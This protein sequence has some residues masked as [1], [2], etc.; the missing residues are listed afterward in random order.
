[1]TSPRVHPAHAGPPLAALAVVLAGWELLARGPLH[2]TVP[3]ASTVLTTMVS[4]AATGSF[5]QNLAETLLSALVGLGLSVLV[6]V[7]V[8]VLFGTSSPVYRSTRFPFE[9][10][11]PIPPIVV[12]PLVIL[13]LG[14]SRE[15]AFL[16]VFFGCFFGI[17]T[18]TMGGVRDVD[19]V[20]I[21]TARSFQLGRAARLRHIVLPSALPFIATSVRIA[22][23]VA[24]IVAVVSEL[25]GGAPGLGREL[26]L[27]QGAGDTAAT[28]AYVTFFGL[29]GLV[30]NS[31]LGRLERR[32]LHWHPS[33]RG[34]VR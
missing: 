13:V 20:A 9:F 19:P 6:G 25:V 5:W 12:L 28:Y 17:V 29:V 7:P 10:L 8:G 27:A 2:D 34:A 32:L 33:V 30:A 22:G 21:D 18:Q 4:L 15:M 1:M 31:A 24:L 16:L 14:P 3:A 11:K 26:L 23:S